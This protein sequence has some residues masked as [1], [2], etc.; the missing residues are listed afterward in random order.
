MIINPE[1]RSR[2]IIKWA[3]GKTGLLQDFSLRFPNSCQRFLEPFLGGGA[4]F[5][6]LSEG[7]P[8]LVNDCSPEL[9]NLYRVVRD[10]PEELM[11]ALDDMTPFYSES[12]YYLVRGWPATPDVAGAARTM[13]LNKTGFNGLYRLNS[14]GFFNVPFGKRPTCPSLYDRQDILA[15]SQRLANATLTCEDFEAV[16]DRTGEGDFVYCD[17]PYHPVSKT[18]SFNS[19]GARGFSAK[20]QERLRDSCLR[21]VERGAAVAVS[22]SHCKFTEELYRDFECYV[23]KAR[24]SINSKGAKR[25]EI[26][27]LMALKTNQLP[28]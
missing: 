28:R 17:P 16:L 3:G 23:T 27:E 13:F 6:S 25:G 24:R 4:V 2:P 7:I 10:Q 9:Y 8:A 14:R 1:T 12:F 20:Q 22:N 26:P 5:L 21:A 18:S 11:S 15:M 19:Y